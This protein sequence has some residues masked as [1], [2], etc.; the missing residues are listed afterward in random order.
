VR[1][2]P[3]ESVR[4]GN[5]HDGE[6]FG[7]TALAAHPRP[8]LNDCVVSHAFPEFGDFAMTGAQA[9]IPWAFAGAEIGDRLEWVSR[10]PIGGRVSNLELP[11]SGVGPWAW[12]RQVSV[13]RGPVRNYLEDVQAAD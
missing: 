9:R 7:E 6:W 8:V 2:P 3:G 4:K 12:P 11:I 1:Q 5:S 10:S 13:P